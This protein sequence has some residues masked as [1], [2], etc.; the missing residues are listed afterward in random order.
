MGL[1]GIGLIAVPTYPTHYYSKLPH[2]NFSNKMATS[3]HALL[4]AIGRKGA[5]N[6]SY[7]SLLIMH[8]TFFDFS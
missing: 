3:D 7:S 1:V 4:E 5:W 2:T 6:G 8:F